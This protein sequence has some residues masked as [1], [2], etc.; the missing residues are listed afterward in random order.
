MQRVNCTKYDS[1]TCGHQRQDHA[2]IVT[3]TTKC[4]LCTECMNFELHKDPEVLHES[5]VV[6]SGTWQGMSSW[7]NE[8]GR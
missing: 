5:G 6:P 1:C 8:G 3:G 7:E 4:S 2:R